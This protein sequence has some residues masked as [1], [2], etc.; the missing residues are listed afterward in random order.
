MILT[1]RSA[2][3]A[4]DIQSA[5]TCYKELYRERKNAAYQL[6][7]DH[8]FNIAENRQF[9]DPRPSKERK[10]MMIQTHLYHLNHHPIN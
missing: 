8:F 9:T 2:K 4:R 10:K 1:E 5:L 7:L 3:V 6:T